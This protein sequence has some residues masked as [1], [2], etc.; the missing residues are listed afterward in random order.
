MSES[1]SI[2]KSSQKWRR[3]H[4]RWLQLA[5]LLLVFCAGCVVGA[6]LGVKSVHA[7]IEYYRENTEALPDAIVP[8]LQHVLELTDGQSVQV[9]EIITRRHSRIIR[10][11][12][13]GSEG[14]HAEFDA[15]ETEIADV[16]DERQAKK[17]SVF[18]DRVRARF[19]P[20]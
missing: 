14:M 7:R 18:A 16:L 11:R 3:A 12:A 9:R 19:L 17:W 5:V 4:P 2:A 20:P 15:M 8:R 10:Y 1:P 6:M 13:E